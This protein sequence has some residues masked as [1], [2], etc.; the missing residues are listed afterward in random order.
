[1]YPVKPGRII[2]ELG[3]ECDYDEVFPFLNDFAQKMP[4][5]A[6]AVSHELMLERK[7]N[8]LQEK[9]DNKNPFTMEYCIKNNMLGCRAWL[10]PYDYKWFGKD[11]F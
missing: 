3:G 10:S 5:K 11:R 1:M 8:D 9:R 7:E 4:F 2:I 6:E